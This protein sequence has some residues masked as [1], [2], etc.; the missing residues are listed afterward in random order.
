MSA[1]SSGENFALLRPASQSSTYSS[2]HPAGKAVD[3]NAVD[4]IS[5][6]ITADSDYNP[7]WK[8]QLAYPVWV[9]H[10]ELTNR[11]PG[12]N[13]GRH[14]QNCA[15]IMRYIFSKIPSGRAIGCLLVIQIVIIVLLQF[16]P[17]N[18]QYNVIGDR[19]IMEPDFIM[20]NISSLNLPTVFLSKIA[21]NKAN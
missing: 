11:V 1:F 10:V 16:L 13:D 5:C 6:S 3:G 12:G 19:V 2:N 4:D 17:W 21:A 14:R 8:V 15:L 9:T 7:W 18:M 20:F